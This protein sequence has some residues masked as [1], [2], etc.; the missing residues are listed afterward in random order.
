MKWSRTSKICFFIIWFVGAVCFILMNIGNVSITYSGFGV[1]SGEPQR[2][3]KLLGK[4]FCYRNRE[5]SAFLLF[6][7]FWTPEPASSVHSLTVIM[8]KGK[9]LSTLPN[10]HLILFL[11]L[12]RSGLDPLFF[13]ALTCV[14]SSAD[15]PG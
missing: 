6:R 15:P 13:F 12:F 11:S 2:K 8:L 1:D 7:C 9:P 5:L 3:G 10:Q 14:P 4:E